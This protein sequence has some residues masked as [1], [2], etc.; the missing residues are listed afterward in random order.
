MR[1]TIVKNIGRVAIG[2]VAIDGRKRVVRS[3]GGTAAVVPNRATE[4]TLS[5][6]QSTK[7]VVLSY[8]DVPVCDAAP[9]VLGECVVG[10]ELVVDAGYWAGADDVSVQW[11]AAGL[12]I[13]GETSGSLLLTEDHVGKMISVVVTATSEGGSSSMESDVVGEVA[14]APVG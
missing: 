12:D 13:E 11:Q 8:S 6:L 2:L 14:P 1:V 7:S 10:I 3:G 4:Q 9:S 5:L